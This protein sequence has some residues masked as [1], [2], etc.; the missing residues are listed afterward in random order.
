MKL[1]IGGKIIV[2]IELAV[3]LVTIFF[4]FISYFMLIDIFRTQTYNQLESIATLKESSIKEFL[5][6]VVSEIEFFNNRS[7]VKT[8][9]GLLLK[10]DD[11]VSKDVISS[12]A[13]DLLTYKKVFSDILVLDKNGVVVFS[14]NASEEGKIRSTEL[15]FMNSTQKTFVQDYLY[16]A[17]TGKLEMMVGTPIKDNK[18]IFVGVLVGRIN[19]DTISN[20][21]TQRS[22]LGSTGETFLVNSFNIVVSDLL[23][24]PGSVMKKTI[25]L[26]QVKSCL[27]GNTSNFNLP[28]YNGDE[29]FGF[30][31][32]FPQIDSCLVSKIDAAEALAPA[33]RIILITSSSVLGVAL[34]LGLL[35]FL[36]ARTIVKPIRKLRESVAKISAGDFNARTEV[37]TSD[38]IGEISLAFNDMAEKLNVSYSELEN[39]IAEKTKDLE[40]KV[41]EL[42]KVNKLMVGRELTMI[43]LKKK[44]KEKENE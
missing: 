1:G 13:M 18:G 21:M 3:V 24:Q 41:T 38:E 20:L 9:L 4:G 11:K 7:T 36:E 23:K 37:S 26:P 28:D 42:E 5:N 40:N 39:K 31:H 32:W 16:D 43:D 6:E 44:L 35:G 25:F 19:V 22:G 17:A 34:L 27:Q 12:R 29:V 10:D 15:Y 2:S 14:T 30:Y 8:Y 33:R